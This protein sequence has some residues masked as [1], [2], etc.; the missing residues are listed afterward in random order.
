[1]HSH[2]SVKVWVI[3]ASILSLFGISLASWQ[4]KY[5]VILLGKSNPVK[6]LMSWSFIQ[7]HYVHSETSVCSCVCCR[8]PSH[9]H[10]FFPRLF[11]SV[12]LILGSFNQGPDLFNILHIAL[13][14]L[15]AFFL[16]F[17]YVLC[18]KGKQMCDVQ[19]YTVTSVCLKRDSS[20]CLL[21]FLLTCKVF[22]FHTME[23]SGNQQL[24][25]NYLFK[26]VLEK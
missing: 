13:T 25:V 9:L 26:C 21:W 12:S 6:H 17:K 20:P 1:M 2:E 24:K 23:V 14:T 11:V 15:T 5:L 3:S 8:E 7:P 22:S 4:W 18:Y 10:V 19:S 16:F